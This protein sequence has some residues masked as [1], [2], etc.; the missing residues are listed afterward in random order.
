L[1]SGGREELDHHR[2]T[3]GPGAVAAGLNEAAEFSLLEPGRQP[4]A[5]P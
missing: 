2:G 5:L 3:G 4:L 1:E